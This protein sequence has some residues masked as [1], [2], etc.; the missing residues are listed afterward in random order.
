MA[1]APPEER[2]QCVK[3]HVNTRMNRR[4]SRK[5]RGP[6]N[7]LIRQLF[8]VENSPTGDEDFDV[9]ERNQARASGALLTQVL[10]VAEYIPQISMPYYALAFAYARSC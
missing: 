6:V 5:G 9:S 8:L 4:P 7:K 1:K 2:A 3:I 10:T